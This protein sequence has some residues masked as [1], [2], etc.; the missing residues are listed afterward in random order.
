MFGNT[1]E[2]AISE[3][4]TGSDGLR[5]Q[6]LYSIRANRLVL[7]KLL[8]VTLRKTLPFWRDSAEP[9]LAAIPAFVVRRAEAISCTVYKSQESKVAFCEFLEL[10]WVQ[11]KAKNDVKPLN[12]DVR[13]GRVRLGIPPDIEVQKFWLHH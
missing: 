4:R 2:R 3:I 7:L 5:P 1:F 9:T 6:F 10:E 13:F 11:I 12:F 8:H